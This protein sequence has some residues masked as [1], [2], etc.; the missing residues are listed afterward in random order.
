MNG[1]PVIKVK[2]DFVAPEGLE[3]GASFT[4]IELEQGSTIR[5]LINRIVELFGETARD[6]L[7][8]PDG[9]TPYVDFIVEGK[10]VSLNH[11]LKPGDEVLVLP[12][13]YGG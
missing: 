2:V 5:D 9:F 11:V 1:V 13:I 4:W 10:T 8:Q 12:P 7:L 6:K 3:K